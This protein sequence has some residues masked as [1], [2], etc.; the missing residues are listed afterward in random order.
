MRL[1]FFLIDEPRDAQRMIVA[2]SRVR[3]EEKIW[4]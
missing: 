1:F 3:D 2:V 4:T